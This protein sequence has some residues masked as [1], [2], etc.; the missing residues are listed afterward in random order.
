MEIQFELINEFGEFKSEIIN[1]TNDEYLAI[2]EMSKN[3]YETGFELTDD[4]GN[5][6]VF[7]P[8]VIKKSILKI[9][10]I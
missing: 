10:I 8:E 1:C 4:S 9:K 6:I 7:T 2:K 3:Y 5:F